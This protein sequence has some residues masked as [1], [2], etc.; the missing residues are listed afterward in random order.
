MGNNVKQCDKPEEGCG[1]GVHA[2]VWSQLEDAQ[3]EVHKQFDLEPEKIDIE[4][5][6]MKPSWSRKRD[7]K[8]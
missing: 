8:S 1:Q 5:K 4:V 2:G 6:Y 3:Q 7:I